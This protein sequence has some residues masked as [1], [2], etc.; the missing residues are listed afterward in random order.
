MSALRSLV[1]RATA[2]AFVVAP[3]LAQAQFTRTF[4]LC[5]D[6]QQFCAG[7]GL[8]LTGSTLVVGLKNVGSNPAANSL[9]S[10]FGLFGGGLTGGTLTGQSFVGSTTPAG[11]F[12]TSFASSGA[13][14]DLQRGD[15][16]QALPVGATFGNNGFQPCGYGDQT[17][18]A[19]V[20]TCAGEY[21]EF[22]FNV[23]GSNIILADV[24]FAVRA[25][26]LQPI[27]GAITGSDKCFS[28]GDANCRVTTTVSI[29]GTVVPEPA[30]VTLLGVGLAGLFAA[31]V[32]RRQG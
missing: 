25:Q 8:S 6:P 9:I 3:A 26:N 13:P 31:G 23:V 14:N 30:T 17:N 5:N 15:G 20:A 22:V 21:G 12:T 24:G 7:V 29:D 32:R 11:I 27:N 28:T 18:P 16:T 2:A 10:G 4:T 19:R 1:V